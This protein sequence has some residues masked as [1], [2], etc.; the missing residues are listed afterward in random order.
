MPIDLP[1]S[2]SHTTLPAP[3]NSESGSPPQQSL[4]LR[5]RSPVTWQPLAGWQMLM[6]LGPGAQRRLQQP[7]QP[8]QTIPSTPPQKLGP[9]GGAAQVPTFAPDAFTH[10]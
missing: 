2:I 1:D 4:S 10:S 6:P 8:S 3:G 5:Q 9:S 7:L